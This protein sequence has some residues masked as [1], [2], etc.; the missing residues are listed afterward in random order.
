MLYEEHLMKSLCKEMGITWVEEA[1]YPKLNG[2]PF[3]SLIEADI[4]SSFGSN[5]VTW[6]IDAL[7]GKAGLTGYIGSDH[8]GFAA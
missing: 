7:T 4:L 2:T 8:A 1:G 5:S 3:T 6:G